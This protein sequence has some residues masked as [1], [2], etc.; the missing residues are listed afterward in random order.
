MFYINHDSG[1]FTVINRFFGNENERKD[2]ILEDIISESSDKNI[3]R[4]ISTH[5]GREHIKGIEYLF[6]KWSTKNFYAVSNKI[7]V[8]KINASLDKYIELR[9][10]C[11]CPIQK[12]KEDLI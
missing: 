5:P 9:D 7:P 3:H 12:K 8:K 6:E 1:S 4:F 2:E 11:N 10:T